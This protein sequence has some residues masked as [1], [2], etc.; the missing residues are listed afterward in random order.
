MGRPVE[1]SPEALDDIEAIA[2]FIARD[3]QFY[4]SSVVRRIQ[5]TART[6][7]E[8]PDLGAVVQEYDVPD[9]RERLVYNYRLIY[10]VLPDRVLVLTIVHGAQEIT[11]LDDDCG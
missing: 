3:S 11:P 9:I 4:A 1:W 6:L 5:E 8:F 2:A 7:S 10:R